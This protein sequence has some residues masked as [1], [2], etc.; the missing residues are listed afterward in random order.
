MI[1]CVATQTA[2]EQAMEETRARI[3]DVARELLGQ[4]PDAGMGDVAAAAGVVRRTVYGH[5]PARNDLVRTL[6][7]Q[8]AAEIAA[9]L[10]EVDV[11][12]TPADE[13]WTRFVHRLWPL[14]HRYRVL[15]ALRR[16]EY[17]DEIHALLGSVDAMLATLILR[18]QKAGAFGTHLPPDALG[19]IG[20]AAVFAIADD[21]G[22]DPALDVRAAAITSLLALGVSADRAH[23]LAD[24]S[25]SD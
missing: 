9:V 24:T 21:R 1:G 6:A 18:G 3:I 4:R 10:E 7:E 23:S 25:L 20:Y 8:A 22:D 12:A 5:F 17:G 15:L 13:A 11:A 14:A 19:R 2:R 16:G